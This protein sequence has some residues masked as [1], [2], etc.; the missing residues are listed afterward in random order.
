MVDD[1]E[2]DELIDAEETLDGFDDEESYEMPE[3][4]PMDLAPAPMDMDTDG[5]ASIEVVPDEVEQDLEELEIDEY[6]D[7]RQDK[8]IH[9]NITVEAK[10]K[11]RNYLLR[12]RAIRLVKALSEAKTRKQRQKLRKELNLLRKALI[13]TEN[14][15][16]KRLAKNLSVILKESKTMRRRRNSW[17]FEGK[18]EAG[19]E[20]I[21]FED[22][23]FEEGGD[24]IEV[25]AAALE[26]ALGLE[27]GTIS[28]ASGGDDDLDM[29]DDLSLIHI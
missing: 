23:E 13:I 19:A 10:R 20:E 29:E 24:T 27:A 25:D 11:K 5:L 21:E 14:S 8:S 28:D 7:E 1:L 3:A 12:H 26:D 9:V 16:N 6:E 4:E 17:L 18:D 15:Q 2:T 22:A